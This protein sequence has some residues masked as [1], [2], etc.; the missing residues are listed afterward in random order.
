MREEAGDRDSAEAL[1]LQAA[2]RGHTDALRRVAEM[3]EKATP[4]PCTAWRRCGRAARSARRG[5]RPTASSQRSLSSTR[6]IATSLDQETRFSC[7]ALWL[8]LGVDE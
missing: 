6:G 3:R 7:Q 8:K 2:D 5:R 4:A 1:A